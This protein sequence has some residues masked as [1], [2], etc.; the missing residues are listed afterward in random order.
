MIIFIITTAKKL[1]SNLTSTLDPHFSVRSAHVWSM[2]ACFFQKELWRL[3][4][5]PDV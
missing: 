3:R 2:V 1:K 4:N 5:S